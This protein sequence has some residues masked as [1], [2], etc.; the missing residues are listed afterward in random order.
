MYLVDITTKRVVAWLLVLA[1]AVVFISPI[2][3]LDPTALRSVRAAQSLQ[4]ALASAAASFSALL[5]G[6]SSN[7]SPSVD[8]FFVAVRGHLFNLNCSRLC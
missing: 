4:M 1:I 2:V 7:F 3:D 8:R 6:L 5:L